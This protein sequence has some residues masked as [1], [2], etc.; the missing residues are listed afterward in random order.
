MKRSYTLSF[1]L[2][3]AVFSTEVMAGDPVVGAIIGGGAGAAVG[4]AIGGRDGAVVGGM[5]GAM[6]GVLVATDKDGHRDPDY[7][8]R[9]E[10]RHGRTYD[11][12]HDHGYGYGYGHDRYDDCDDDRHDGYSRVIYRQAPTVVYR[13]TP[14]VVVKHRAPRVVVYERDWHPGH[15]HHKWHGKHHRHAYAY[16]DHDD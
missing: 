1:L 14:V 12:D 8:V 13:E 16:H 5:L 4:N 11:H 3:G 15:G 9:R 10:A 7:R 2:L 6:T